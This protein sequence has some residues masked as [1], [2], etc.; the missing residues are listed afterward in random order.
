MRRVT[1]LQREVARL[2]GEGLRPT[3]IARETGTERAYVYV[4]LARLSLRANPSGAQR[5]LEELA[6]ATRCGRCHLLG[7]HECLPPA[8]VVGA[9]RQERA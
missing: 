2:N 1:E 7:E 4:T 8:W 9:S 6:R 5:K 3:E